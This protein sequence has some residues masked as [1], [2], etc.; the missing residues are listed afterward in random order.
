MGREDREM[1]TLNRLTIVRNKTQ[2]NQSLK[3]LKHFE[4]RN[5]K[6]DME[7]EKRKRVCEDRK[8][9]LVLLLLY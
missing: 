2:N 9:R 6:E 4:N 3:N 7:S 5:V 1:E 8:A